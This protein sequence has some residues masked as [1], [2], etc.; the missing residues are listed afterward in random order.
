MTWQETPYTIPLIAT[1]GVSLVLALYAWR[2]RPAAGAT[3]LALFMLAAAEWSLTYALELGSAELALKMVWAK[4]QYLGISTAAPL[5]LLLVLQYTGRERW[6][7]PKPLVFIAIVPVIALVSAWTNEFHHLL[8]ADTRLGSYGSFTILELEHGVGFWLFVAFSYLCLLWGMY[9]LVQAFRRSPPMYRAQVG[10]MLAGTL[11][12]WLANAVYLSG[13]NPFPNLDLT[14]FAFTL[15]GLSLTWGLFRFQLLDIVPIARDAVLEGMSDGVIVLDRQDRIV[16]INPAA[17]GMLGRPATEIIGKPVERTSSA[18]WDVVSRVPHHEAAQEEIAVVGRKGRKWHDLQISPLR[19]RTGRLVVVRDITERKGVERERE[20]LIEE[21]D[22]FAHSVA[23][24]LKTSLTSILGFVALLRRQYASMLDDQG[25]HYIQIAQRAASKMNDI[26]D[27]LLLLASVR[28]EEQMPVVPVDMAGIVAEVLHRL[29]LV[30]E[31]TQAEISLPDSWQ[32]ATGYGPWLEEVW[33]N[34]L[35]NGLKYGG[36]PPRLELGSETQPD[37][38]V[39]FWVRDNGPG[40]TPEEQSQLFM[41]FARL[42]KQESQGHGLGLSIV[43]RIVER[44]DGQAGV[45]STV[46]EG[47]VFVFT[48]PT[49]SE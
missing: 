19:N 36:D 20:L 39:R 12:P 31:Q 15:T 7:M 5:M 9:L 49:V 43:Q 22:A 28:K 30:I 38:M 40:L 10:V 46:G 4:A 35:S 23:H 27:A 33:T 25:R 11:A 48:L 6:L 45:E 8:W 44:L 2:R 29:E 3:P 21:L 47:S 24:D 17:E 18:W 13:L 32:V 26:I 41:P 1:A 16:D 42:N 14:P 37:G 34:Y